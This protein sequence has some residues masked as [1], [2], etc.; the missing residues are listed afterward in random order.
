MLFEL[1]FTL[2]IGPLKLVLEIIYMVADRFINHPGLSIIFLSLTMNALMLPIYLRADAIQKA[3]RDTKATLSKDCR[4]HRKL[5][6]AL[7]GSVL[8]LLEI[9]F[10]IAAYQFLSPLPLLEGVSLGPIADLSMPDALLTVSGRSINLL[11]L[12][13]TLISIVSSMIYLKGFPIKTKLQ[14]YG[15]ALLFLVFLY[16][17]PSGLVVYWMLNNL[18]SL[19]K[20]IF[21]KLKKPRKALALLCSAAGV[22]VLFFSLVIYSSGSIKIRIALTL[23]GCGFE[24]PLLHSLLMRSV[25]G[26]RTHRSIKPNSRFF[27][28]CCLFLTV[29]IGALIPTTYISASPQEFVDI[30][31]FYNPLWYVAYSFCFA[32][33]FFLL[34]MRVLYQLAQPKGRVILDW[35]AFI[36]CACVM[37]NYLFFGTDL[38]II[39]ANLKYETDLYFTLSEQLLNL[40]VLAAAA[41][42]LSFIFARFHQPLSI[43]MLILIVE[44]GSMSGFNMVKIVGPVSDI[45]GLAEESSDH[46][47]E[48][49]LSKTGKNVVVI[50]LDRGLGY[51]V[52]FLMEE[53]PEL[54]EQFAGFTH[55]NNTISFGMYTHT[56]SPALLGGYEYT[57]VEMNRRDTEF[58]PDKH[59]ESLLVMPVSFLKEGFEVTVCDPPLSGYGTHSPLSIFDEYPEI[60]SY[61]TPGRFGVEQKNASTTNALNRN[62][63]CFSLM[64]ASPLFMQGL[65]YNNSWYNRSDVSLDEKSSW[66][67]TLFGLSEAVGIDNEFLNT[68]SV[69]ENLPAITSIVEEDV[70]TYLFFSND[71]THAPTLLQTPDFVP[72]TYVDNTAY[73]AEYGYTRTAD[74]RTLSLKN[75]QQIIHYHVNMAAFLQLGK[76]FDY[77]KENDVYDNTRIILSAD[78]GRFLSH[79]DELTHGEEIDFP[80]DSDCFFP[81]LMVKDFGAT[82]YTTSYEFMT[83][84]DVPTL[85]MQGVIE[86]PTNPFT[87]KAINS[88]EK[89]AHEQFIYLSSSFDY[90]NNITSKTYPPYS[91]ASV[92]S[93]RWNPDCWTLFHKSVILKEHSFEAQSKD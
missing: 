81:L 67:Q 14:F 66:S 23:L 31:N 79:L 52:P 20:N 18:F 68:Y 48:I 83:N 28:L 44:F 1:L 59:D 25:P 71:T 24:L 73:D 84:A 63:F 60:N 40:V 80:V 75:D 65:L 88:N 19:T 69:L 46:F 72:S 27:F 82:E 22:V 2:L 70:N 49:K 51:I 6:E 37:I 11:P 86:K 74:G 8:L 47:P 77:L 3:F 7:K 93:D 34:W 43:L 87:G 35:L 36:L 41:L 12:L 85:A 42:F 78:H 9:P 38:G 5:T 45:R 90:T 89:N 54:R 57:P 17:S 32:A 4:N 58:Q 76:W 21:Y 62:F 30:Y 91:W 16:A 13:T 50:M 92:H 39:S 29:F 33:G 55:Y 10:F 53:K 15:M 61:L 26:S 64:K 56:G